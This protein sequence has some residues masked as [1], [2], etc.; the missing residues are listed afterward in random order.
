MFSA[1]E[2]SSLVILAAA[3][4]VQAQLS[5][6]ALNC[7][8]TS[9]TAAGCSSFSDLACICPNQQYMS[10]V[11]TCWQDCGSGVQSAAQAVQSAE[12]AAYVSDT[13]SS[14]SAS[15]VFSTASSTD[16][17]VSVPADTTFSAI[18]ASP[19]ALSTEPTSD[20][21]ASSAT[22]LTKFAPGASGSATGSASPVSSGSSGSSGS[23]SASGRD[24]A[25]SF[26]GV[27]G[28]GVAVVAAI[29]GAGL[30]I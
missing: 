10:S 20:T 11:N 2:L 22:S 13:P 1:I 19:T 17:S 7:I 12:C 24:V 5:A 3:V 25:L 26:H 30:V 21:A 27:I 8:E 18:S 9:A 23:S 14:T 28:V 4:G 6:C 16:I 29:A 15:P